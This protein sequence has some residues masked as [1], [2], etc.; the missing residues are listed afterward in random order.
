MH[1]VQQEGQPQV[2]NVPPERL[3]GPLQPI[4]DLFNQQGP[5]P[6]RLQALKR[7]QE[8]VQDGVPVLQGVY[9]LAG[10]GPGFRHLAV[11]PCQELL[12][13]GSDAQLQRG[14]DSLVTGPPPDPGQAQAGNQVQ[15]EVIRGPPQCPADARQHL[16]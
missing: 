4:A 14:D 10:A 1:L 2:L 3:Q 13:A 11:G 9:H 5:H 16:V 12:R 7:S 6:H 15:A 8:F